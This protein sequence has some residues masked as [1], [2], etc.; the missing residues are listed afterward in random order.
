MG[1]T[2][3][4]DPLV[5]VSAGPQVGAGFVLLCLA[6]RLGSDAGVEVPR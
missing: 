1:C 2:S 4:P 3:F 5:V 6:A